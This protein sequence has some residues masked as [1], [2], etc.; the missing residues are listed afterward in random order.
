MAELLTIARP[1]AEAAFKLA[2]DAKVSGGDTSASL[3][4]WADALNRLASVASR[5]ELR[6]LLGNPKVTS[7]QLVQLIGDAAGA[8][9]EPQKNFL[10]ILA[11]QERLTALS[12]VEQHFSALRSRFEATLEAEVTS[13]FALSDVQLA[14]IVSTL[15]SKYG[16]KVKATVK[17]DNSLIGGV[18]IRVGDEVTDV[19]VRG[20]LAQLRASLMA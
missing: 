10:T 1:Y 11:G 9:N 13:A 17:V 14:D 6:N 18:S 12:E 19:S 4:S 7:Q 8:M 16:K 5:P 20:K 3:A 2:T 15:S